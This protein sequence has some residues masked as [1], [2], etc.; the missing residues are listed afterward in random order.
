MDKDFVEHETTL[1]QETIEE[2][3]DHGKTPKD[4]R[5]C[6]KTAWAEND[7][8]KEEKYYFTWEEFAEVSNFEYEGGFG[9]KEILLDLVIAGDDFWLER[10]EYDG[11]EWWEFKTLPSRPDKKIIPTEDS[12]R[13]KA[14]APPKCD[15][16]CCR[17]NGLEE[18]SWYHKFQDQKLYGGEEVK[19]YGPTLHDPQ[20]E[21]SQQVEDAIAELRMDLKRSKEAEKEGYGSFNDTERDRYAFLC[22]RQQCQLES[23]ITALKE[24]VKTAKNIEAL[25]RQANKKQG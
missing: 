16:K 5:W 11:A 24:E 13:D 20:F 1:L 3:K 19:D 21:S 18:K 12:L 15:C 6:G 4:V 25:E 8:A 10:H 9:I 23:Q 14:A 17:K 22:C 2:L 7:Y